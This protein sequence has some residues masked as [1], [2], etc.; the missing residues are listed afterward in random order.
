MK[1][2][3]VVHEGNLQLYHGPPCLKGACGDEGF[4][5]ARLNEHSCRCPEGV[6]GSRCERRVD[7]S[8]FTEGAWFDGQTGYSYLNRAS[9]AVKGQ[10]LSNYS[11]WIRTNASEGLIWWENKGA[12][13]KYDF[14][15]I[16]LVRSRISFAV[17]LGNDA[18]LKTITVNN[19]APVNDNRWHHII[20]IREKRNSEMTVD[21]ETVSHL[22]SPGSTELNTDGV[23]WIGM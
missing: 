17:S 1:L 15:A 6:S 18:T 21:G 10:H 8:E 9:F 16:F 14:M 22:T 20:F 2:Q 3:S 19:T 11:F 23:V 7:M 4:C 13:L 5:Y 12:T